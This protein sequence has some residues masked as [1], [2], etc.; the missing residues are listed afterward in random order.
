[1]ILFDVIQSH[2]EDK[3]RFHSQLHEI[4]NNQSALRRAKK[5]TES[6]TTWKIHVFLKCSISEVMN[7]QNKMMAA[8]KKILN[9]KKGMWKQRHSV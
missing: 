7:E 5:K 4:Q 2:D 9:E 6:T 3:V 1:M 8:Q